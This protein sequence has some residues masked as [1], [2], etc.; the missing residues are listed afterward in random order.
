MLVY[1]VDKV[2]ALLRGKRDTTSDRD[3]TRTMIKTR[4]TKAA[5]HTSSIRAWLK[6][7]ILILILVAVAWF[8]VIPQYDEASREIASLKNVSFALVIVAALLELGSLIAFSSLT[9]VVLGRVRPRFFTIL[10]IDLT[11]LGVNH[12]APGGGTTAAA[13]RFELLKQAGVALLRL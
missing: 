9:A 7:L 6:Q 1:G 10:R 5:S 3:Y 4:T 12:V 11:D 2:A 13:V 8:V